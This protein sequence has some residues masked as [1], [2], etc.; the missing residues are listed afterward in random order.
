M[1][2]CN[3]KP[4][5]EATRA[6]ISFR[7]KK[8]LSFPCVIPENHP[9]ESIDIASNRIKELPTN[10]PHLHFLDY[11]DN[12]LRTIS[13]DIEFAI[14]SYPSLSEFRL[15]LNNLEKIPDSFE[16]LT[17]LHYLYLNQNKIS[18]FSLRISS[19]H[20]LDL[21]CNLL[22]EFTSI[23]ESLSV[24]DLSFNRL[25]QIQFMSSSLRELKLSGNDITSLPS[26]VHFSSLT[27]LD[28]SYNKL[29]NINN[30]KS[31]SPHLERLSA[32]FNFIDVFPS[33]PQT[34]RTIALEYNR[35]TKIP[36]LNSYQSL[37]CLTLNNNCIETI[38]QLPQSLT[39]LSLE[40]NRI[41]STS[42]ISLTSLPS[43]SI[44]NNNLQNIPH[45]TNSL[46]TVFSGSYN[47]IH[48]I[49]IKEF[50]QTIT[51][52]DLSG[53]EI[54]KLP[55]QLFLLP[56]LK[57]LCLFSNKISEIPIEISVS[58][59]QVLNISRN[60][61]KTLPKLPQSLGLLIAHDCLFE[62]IPVSVSS[63]TRISLIDFSNN[64]VKS[65]PFLPNAES[66]FLSCNEITEF[67]VI[68]ENIREVDISH[69]KIKHVNI[70]HNHPYLNELNISNNLLESYQ[71]QTKLPGLETLKL[72]NNP[73]LNLHFLFDNYPELDCLDIS[74]TNIDINLSVP[75]RNM[76]EIIESSSYMQTPDT[77]VFK[78]NPK[79]G[80]AEMKGKRVTMEDALII[81]YNNHL[82]IFAVIDGH[83]GPCTANLTAFKL[84]QL[85][86]KF[87]LNS[88]V[89]SLKDL[90][91]FLREE[92]ITDG[93]T[94]A[95]V[96]QQGNK[97]IAANI[98]DSRSLIVRSN[99]SVFP[100]S[101]DHKPY[102]RSELE[103]IRSN[104][105]YVDNM[106]TQGILAISRS[107][108]DFKLI[109]VSAVPCINEYTIQ[110]SDYRLL[111]ACDGVF[112]VISNELAGQIVISE[113]SPSVAAHK[114]RNAAYAMQSDDNISVIVVDLK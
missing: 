111:I 110:E 35:L 84:P 34:I 40:Y 101:Y 91:N 104:G 69:N 41:E 64:K 18:K 20:E 66:L 75:E 100:L 83:A 22:K 33:F 8:L 19:L 15:S 46:I 56:E 74:Q 55:N 29:S 60:P 42:S 73:K 26:N 87:D 47:K 81:Q 49:N 82:N 98:G 9:I 112:D 99:G 78:Y 96:V 45:F 61:I 37:E 27:F 97:L 63:L 105:S 31:F 62:D 16:M 94:L 21:S 10:L 11:S 67:P 109:G 90:N 106:R 85:I 12:D 3:S 93:A 50:S 48:D 71:C 2:Q 53:N 57:N 70:N 107:L 76:R 77:K 59:I 108:G 14:L 17:S 65:V 92:N 25:T 43:L 113:E 52:L 80:Y 114:L 23:S 28:I 4:Q 72:N 39:T 58:Q 95:L 88:I 1:G 24:L 36:P 89:N 103:R 102:E 32:E 44:S 6:S 38:Q 7:E 30:I 79:V 13:K 5:I 51:Q 54:E 86:T 68:L